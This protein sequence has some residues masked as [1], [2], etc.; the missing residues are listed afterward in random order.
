MDILRT[1]MDI[2]ICTVLRKS[3]DT[4]DAV[5]I[6]SVLVVTLH[7]HVCFIKSNLLIRTDTGLWDEPWIPRSTIS[8]QTFI[9]T[10]PFHGSVRLYNCPPP[11]YFIQTHPI[12]LYFILYICTLNILSLYT[13]SSTIE[14]YALYWY[15]NCRSRGAFATGG[16]SVVLVLKELAHVTDS[17]PCITT[18]HSIQG[19]V[20]TICRCIGI[21]RGKRRRRRRRNR[22]R[23]RRRIAIERMNRCR[24]CR[25]I[26]VSRLQSTTVVCTL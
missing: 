19:A 26:K 12:R 6:L 5:C 17:N 7:A 22:K 15:G 3:T 24:D 4:L 9:Q 10:K 16:P 18:I 2:Q 21:G 20:Y 14:R 13:L 11:E 23:K 8:S 25:K 1:D